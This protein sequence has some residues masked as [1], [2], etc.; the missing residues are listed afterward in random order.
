MIRP[1]DNEP[2]AIAF[3]IHAAKSLRERYKLCF[4]LL[5]HLWCGFEDNDVGVGHQQLCSNLRKELKATLHE[6]FGVTEHVCRQIWAYSKS[7][8]IVR[9]IAHPNI[10]LATIPYH[11]AQRNLSGHSDRLH[12]HQAN[13]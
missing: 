1:Y 10:L 3:K 13:R 8:D 7:R 5:P 6:H 9:I 11:Q 2:S 4:V 12:H